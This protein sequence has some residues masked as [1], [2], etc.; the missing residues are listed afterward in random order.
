M[1]TNLCLSQSTHSVKRLDCP[2][3]SLSSTGLAFYFTEWTTIIFD[4]LQLNGRA[5]FKKNSSL[6][7]WAKNSRTTFFR[8]FPKEI[9]CYLSKILMTFFLV[10]YLFT[11]FYPSKFL[12][13][14]ISQ[15]Y[16]P[17]TTSI[18]THMLFSTFLQLAFHSRNSECQ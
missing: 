7:I 13:L 18:H 17:F 14:R 12:P 6:H 9:L 15:H 11:V 8:I 16:T 2:P 3:E 4:I 1:V 5:C 10:I